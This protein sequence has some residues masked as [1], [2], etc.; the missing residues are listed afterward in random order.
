MA[1]T[2][3]L[4]Q[5]GNSA[6]PPTDPAAYSVAYQ[7]KL[8]PS[9]FGRSRSV[10]FNRANASLDSALQGDVEFADMM[11]QLIPGVQDSVSSVG[12]RATPS[13]WVWEHASSSTAL[14]EQGVMRL[15]PEAQHTPGSN[16]WRVLH[17]DPG[18]AGGYSERAIPNG[19]PKT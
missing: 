12:G 13:G 4:T 11:Q 9:D 19:A 15:V 5:L 16:W 8:N 7:M 17:P 14:G 10:Q 1:R 6:L 2:S 18:A 3:G